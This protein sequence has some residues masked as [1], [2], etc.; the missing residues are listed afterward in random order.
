M[1]S[2]G[3]F[4]NGMTFEMERYFAAV[5]PEMGMKAKR[6]LEVNT[7]HPAWKAFDAARITNPEKAGKYAQ[8]LYN[9]A[10]LIA[11]FPLPNPTE[12]TDLVTSLF[13]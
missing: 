8:I 4:R 12:Y 3:D 1:V 13:D 2:A 6:I 7:E 11:G 5:Q 10:L 9:Q